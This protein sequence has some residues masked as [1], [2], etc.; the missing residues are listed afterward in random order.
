[1]ELTI[2]FKYF[3]KLATTI[4]MMLSKPTSLIVCSPV[5]VVPVYSTPVK[6]LI[7]LA[8]FF[9]VDFITG[10]SASYVEFKRSLPVLPGQGKRY[11][12]QSSKLRLSAVKFGTYCIMILGAYGIE[13]VFV[14]QEFEPH[15]NLQKMTLT[16]IIIA[17]C[18]AIELYSIL[19]EN[20][21][22]MGFDIIQKVKNIS[23]DGWDIFKTVKDEK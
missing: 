7:L 20:V 13:W 3:F 17:F 21:K 2:Y 19:F 11:V 18:C 23:K 14:I 16:T 4:K 12:I 1:M 6:A 10:I 22:R 15:A 9:I 8:F 5:F